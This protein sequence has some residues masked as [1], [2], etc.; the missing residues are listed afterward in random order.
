MTRHRGDT[1]EIKETGLLTGDNDGYIKGQCGTLG[2]LSEIQLSLDCLYD[3]KNVG[4]TPQI[5]NI[6]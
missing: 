5:F 4:N 2:V 6:L 3:T 1:V